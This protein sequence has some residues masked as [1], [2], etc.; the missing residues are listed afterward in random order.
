MP[1]NFIDFPV[2]R[3]C[4]GLVF[5][6]EALDQRIN[7]HGAQIFPGSLTHGY[8]PGLQLLVAHHELVGQLL[9]AV[10]PD[11]VADL[12]VAG[13]DIY[14]QAGAVAVRTRGGE[15]LGAMP[16][17]ALIDRLQSESA[18]GKVARSGENR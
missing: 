12:F 4:P 14:P 18:P 9:Q 16:V 11:L 5:R 13:V 7:G 17:D 3:L 15:D 6:L 2:Q 8:R 10:L 1:R